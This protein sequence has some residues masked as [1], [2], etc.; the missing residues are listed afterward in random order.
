MARLDAVAAAL[1]L[2]AQYEREHA[3]YTGIPAA[4]RAQHAADR[5]RAAANVWKL[6]KLE[7]E[8]AAMV[9]VLEAAEDLANYCQGYFS[10]LGHTSASE[11]R[12]ILA[13]YRAARA[14]VQP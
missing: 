7:R 14:K 6:A 2:A 1:D 9:E 12:R 11:G 4:A 13:A 3:C 10:K 8:H 5:E